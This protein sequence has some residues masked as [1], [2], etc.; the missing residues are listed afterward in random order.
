MEPE[1]R[2]PAVRGRP[3]PSCLVLTTL[4]S[5][6][7]GVVGCGGPSGPAVQFV[8]GKV[9]LGGQPVEG[10]TVGLS[11]VQG[12]QGL[13]A[14]ARTDAAGTFRVT[15]TRGGRRDAGATVGEYIVTVTKEESD[16]GAVVEDTNDPNY[17]KKSARP[18]RSKQP[19]SVV[20]EVYGEVST[21]PLRMTVRQG[22][23]DGPAFV[24]DLKT[25]AP[26]AGAPR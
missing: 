10:A 9:L 19:R 22:K 16:G 6:V 8:E 21:S 24:F 14:Y 3:Q 12:S 20:P 1:T 7:L 13:P 18:V 23:N 11:P 2:N 4:A 26:A 25:A 15:S 17:G 5:V